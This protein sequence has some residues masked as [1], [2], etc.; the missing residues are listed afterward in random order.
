MYSHTSTSSLYLQSI[1]ITHPGWVCVYQKHVYFQWCFREEAPLQKEQST[2]PWR[3]TSH[4]VSCKVVQ[5]VCMPCEEW[6]NNICCPNIARYCASPTAVHALCLLV[7]GLSQI[8][9]EGHL[10]KRTE[11]KDSEWQTGF[12]MCC[13]YLQN[14]LL[15]GNSISTR[16]PN[17][18]DEI[19]AIHHWYPPSWSWLHPV[20]KEIVITFITVVTYKRDLC[21]TSCSIYAN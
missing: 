1:P 19:Q 14:Q 17:E 7:W 20:W 10:L 13:A 16:N 8:A 21:R 3:S 12:T 9:R 11:F 6:S 5:R 2:M 15:Q 4:R 18:S